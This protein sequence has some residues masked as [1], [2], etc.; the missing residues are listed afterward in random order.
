MYR[1]GHHLWD[2]VY[3]VK[4]LDKMRGIDEFCCK[5]TLER[6]AMSKIRIQKICLSIQHQ[7]LA[8]FLF[9]FDNEDQIHSSMA[10]HFPFPPFLPACQTSQEHAGILQMADDKRLLLA[11]WPSNLSSHAYRSH[12]KLQGSRQRVCIPLPSG[13][14]K[15]T[16]A[17][18]GACRSTLKSGTLHFDTVCWQ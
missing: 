7:Q 14:A 15:I 3:G 13:R 1:E 12:R 5:I 11:A 2:P 17:F 10:W 4:V 9:N 16:Q 18:V 6:Y 8:A